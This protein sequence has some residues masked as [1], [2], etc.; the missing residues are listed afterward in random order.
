MSV[1]EVL[2]YTSSVMCDRSSSEIHHDAEENLSR[3]PRRHPSGLVWYSS[4]PSKEVGAL[5]ASLYRL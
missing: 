1:R 5:F 3:Y 4:D 2:E